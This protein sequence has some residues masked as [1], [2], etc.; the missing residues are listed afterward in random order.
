MLIN[1]DAMIVGPAYTAAFYRRCA[2]F[3]DPV[4]HTAADGLQ[5]IRGKLLRRPAVLEFLKKLCGILRADLLSGVV[6]NALDLL[7]AACRR[8]FLLKSF[9]F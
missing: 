2:A 5:L 1:Q 7:G 9:L 3:R 4:A 8:D 6:Q